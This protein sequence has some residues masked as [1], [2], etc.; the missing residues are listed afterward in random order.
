MSDRDG[1]SI[2]A[3]A[4]PWLDELTVLALWGEFDRQVSAGKDLRAAREA[5][6]DLL[7]GLHPSLPFPL[8]EDIAAATLLRAEG[9]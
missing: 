9:G 1:E 5:V 6:R 8:L 4:V 2:P 3:S 7:M